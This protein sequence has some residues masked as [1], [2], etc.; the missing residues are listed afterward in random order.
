MLMLHKNVFC[1]FWFIGSKFTCSMLFAL[2]K[3]QLT[4]CWPLLQLKRR[5]N[6]SASAF[7]NTLFFTKEI[8]KCESVL[9]ASSSSFVLVA[10]FLLSVFFKAFFMMC[11]CMSVRTFLPALSHPSNVLNLSP[12]TCQ[13]HWQIFYLSWFWH[14]LSFLFFTPHFFLCCHTSAE[15]QH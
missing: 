2:S 1:H 6:I 5:W 14:I 11:F 8:T 10:S 3:E 4:L 7:Q 15:P 13:S 12:L 9:P